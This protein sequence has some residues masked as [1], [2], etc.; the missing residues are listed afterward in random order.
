MCGISGIVSGHNVARQLLASIQNLEYRGYDSCGMAVMNSHGPVVRKNIGYVADVAEKELFLSMEG[1]MGIA[2]TRWA[3]H[4]GVTPANAHP[5]LS[6]D[7]GIAV[8][9]NGIISNYMEL[10]ESLMKKRHRFESDTD[11][12]VIPHL[13]EDYRGRGFSLER[14]FV[15][16]LKDLDGAF[17]VAM[18][19]KEEPHKIFCGKHES[20]LIIGIG[21]DASYIGSDFNAFIEHTRDA[22]VMDDGEYA[23]VTRESQ[24]IRRISDG[25]AVS[26]KVMHIEWDVEMSRKGGFPH[27][28]LKEIYEQPETVR[29]A[30]AIPDAAILGLARGIAGAKRAYLT[31]VGTTYY[32]AQL[33]QYYLA[34]EAGLSVPAISAD[35]FLE[36]SPIT[37]EDYVLAVSQSGETYDTLRLIREVKARKGRTAAIVNVVGSTLSR[38]VDET[39]MQGSGP[40]ICV[41]STKAALAQVIILIRVALEAGAIAGKLSAPEKKLKLRQLAALPDVI[42]GFL[43][44]RSGFVHLLAE[45]HATHHNWLFMGRGK[46]YPVALESAL[47]AKEV[48]YIHAEGMPAGFL[49][50]GTMAMIDDSLKSLMFVPGE[51]EKELYRM[52]MSSV[53]E[54]NARGGKV[55]GFHFSKSLRGSRLFEDQI[56]LPPTPPLTSP[57]VALVAGQLFS[58]FLATTLGRNVDKPRSLAKS[59]TVA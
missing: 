35:E 17:A 7:K 25:E 55:V 42:S 46:F 38:I 33:G 3:T 52:T 53:E 8:V 6:C 29:R 43:N 30:L 10:K 11:S 36:T 24:A 31:G 44:E 56:I 51:E 2:H 40:E 22:V 14:A 49:K 45:K 1:V 37:D 27:Y 18:I 59:V 9:H 13:I 28:M 34:S 20:P 26:K 48:S 41:I 19:S 57:L 39:V 23:V 12:E 50:H 21:R 54:I 16:A 15:A 58:Y 47:K 32:A 4:G 5:H